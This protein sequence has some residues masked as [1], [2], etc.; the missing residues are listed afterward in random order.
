MLKM[1]LREWLEMLCLEEEYLQTFENNFFTNMERIADV[2]DDELTS[3]LDIEKI[4]H[5]KR[6]LLSLAGSE[7]MKDR[8]GKVT[9][10]GTPKRKHKVVVSPISI[11]FDFQRQ[12]FH[13]F[14]S[15]SKRWRKSSRNRKQSRKFHRKS[16]LGRPQRALLARAPRWIKRRMLSFKTRQSKLI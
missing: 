4:G 13:Q 1:S 7:G 10:E 2:W 3:I 9:D 6:I 14:F 5:R 16:P 11:L 8:F 12:S 15:H